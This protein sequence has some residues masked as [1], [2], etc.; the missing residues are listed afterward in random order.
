MNTD[1]K[2]QTK[3]VTAQEALRELVNSVIEGKKI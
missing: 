1:T 2:E 3:P